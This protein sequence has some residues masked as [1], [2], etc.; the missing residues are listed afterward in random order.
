[1][2]KKIAVAVTAVAG[3]IA[4]L[5]PAS[6]NAAVPAGCLVVNGPSGI[7]IQVGYAP[8]GPSD[9]QHIP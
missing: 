2:K 3:A 1:M 5:L 7:H 6:S 8:N 4:M 9:C